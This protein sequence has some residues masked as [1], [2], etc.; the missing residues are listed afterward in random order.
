[1]SV[2]VGVTTFF[3]GVNG[4]GIEAVDRRLVFGGVVGGGGD[5]RD[6]VEGGSLGVV[7]W[8]EVV[9]RSS[10]AEIV[11]MGGV[12]AVASRSLATVGLIS[13]SA[14][15]SEGCVRG[16]DTVEHGDAYVSLNDRNKTLHSPR[17]FTNAGPSLSSKA[18]LNACNSGSGGCP[19]GQ[20]SLVSFSVGCVSL[21]SFLFVRGDLARGV[22][23]RE[24]SSDSE[25]VSCGIE[26]NS[27]CCSGVQ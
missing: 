5:L 7:G 22:V 19:G 21:A 27:A 9:L 4:N 16:D 15:S 8:S 12:G 13:S 20:L 11:G 6:G 23:E 17:S 26:P 18:R 24:V 25:R 10:S 14:S 2:L 3:V 1:M